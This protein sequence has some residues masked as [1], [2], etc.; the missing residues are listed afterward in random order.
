MIHYNNITIMANFKND[1]MNYV[2]TTI[3][4]LGPGETLN[5]KLGASKW[6]QLDRPACVTTTAPSNIRNIQLID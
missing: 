1:L 6:W 3:I 5:Y 2:D 4:S